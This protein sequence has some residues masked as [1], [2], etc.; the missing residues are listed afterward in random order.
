MWNM[1]IKLHQSFTSMLQSSVSYTSACLLLTLM[2]EPKRLVRPNGLCDTPWRFWSFESRFSWPPTIPM[3]VRQDVRRDK[4]RDYSRSAVSASPFSHCKTYSC[5]E[6]KTF[7]MFWTHLSLVLIHS[8]L[9]LRSSYLTLCHTFFCRPSP[10]SL[11][12]DAQ[13][14]P[15]RLKISGDQP[16]NMQPS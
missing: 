2:I 13:S 5:W 4:T 3:S 12:F 9:L 11:P 8:F 15:P 6:K 16:C 14:R 7:N 1:D 10:L